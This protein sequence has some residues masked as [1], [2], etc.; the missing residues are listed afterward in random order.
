MTELLA[1]A[2]CKHSVHIGNI[3]FSSQLFHHENS[4]NK[5]EDSLQNVNWNILN[6][7]LISGG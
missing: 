2:T 4:C 5:H 1:T 3:K 6:Q 7:T